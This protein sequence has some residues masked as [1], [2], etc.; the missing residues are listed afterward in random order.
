MLLRQGK[1]LK[2]PPLKCKPP[3]KRHVSAMGD[4]EA[5]ARDRHTKAP[6]KGTESAS[7]TNPTRFAIRRV[8][9]GREGAGNVKLQVEPSCAPPPIIVPDAANTSS[10][11]AEAG[12]SQNK[13]G[14]KQ[15]LL[16]K[17]D[18][19]DYVIKH[20]NRATQIRPNNTDAFVKILKEL[21]EAKHHY[22]S[23]NNNS[24]KYK[25]FVLYGLDADDEGEIQTNLKQYGLNPAQ[26][27]PMRRKSGRTTG[28]TNFIVYFDKESQITLQTLKEAK[29]ICRTVISWAHYRQ[30]AN[31]CI[32]CKNCLRYKHN[33]ESCHMPP[34]CMFCAQAH[35]SSA[36]PLLKTRNATEASS[37][38]QHQLK[39]ANCKGN[40][41]AVFKFCP[42]RLQLIS[43]QQQQQ[44]HPPQHIATRPQFIDAPPPLSN[45]WTTN[46]QHFPPLNAPLPKRQPVPSITRSHSPPQHNRRQQMTTPTRPKPRPTPSA[47]HSRTPKIT[48]PLNNAKVK[49][50]KDTAIFL[51][52][53]YQ[54]NISHKLTHTQL[55]PTSVFSPQE[56][57]RIFQEIVRSISTCA[58]REEQ[59]NAL[60]SLALTYMN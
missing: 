10:N 44:Q 26:I 13:I 36:C 33:T 12:S 18:Q 16:T 51:N 11:D 24:P 39:C 28:P 53:H 25:K 49:V 6:E 4:A 35:E 59:L 30:P 55:T 43:R 1:A 32:Q 23:Y 21:D 2:T 45:V 3:G 34:S 31:T 58:T 19:G 54:N 47:D 42:A 5:E 15:L 48:T 9:F 27:K 20:L 40:H 50:S 57:M 22:Y 37:I 52:P 8:F 14:V 29:Y 38:P 41:T 56:L 60:M 46:K 7:A 17:L